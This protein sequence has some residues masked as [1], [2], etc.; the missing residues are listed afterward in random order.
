[1]RECNYSLEC[2]QY[3]ECRTGQAIEKDGYLVCTCCG[4]CLRDGVIDDRPEWRNFWDDTGVDKGRAGMASC[5]GKLGSTMIAGDRGFLRNRHMSIISDP[6]TAM[7]TREETMI[8]N[9]GQIL[10]LADV[11]TMRVRY[12]RFVT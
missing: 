9:S 1:M 7:M 4:L 11:Y 6:V 12:A 10:Q 5:N 8:V 3:P 2:T